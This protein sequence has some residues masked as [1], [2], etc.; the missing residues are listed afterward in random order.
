MPFSKQGMA[1]TSLEQYRAGLHD[2]FLVLAF[3][4]DAIH[5]IG[6]PKHHQPFAERK[7]GY[8]RHSGCERRKQHPLPMLVQ[9]VS[10]GHVNDVG[11]LVLWGVEPLH[12][13]GLLLL[14]LHL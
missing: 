4:R 13:W 12:D 5:A 2:P 9:V 8:H 11:Q 7:A 14:R 6:G 1:C 10:D 3:A